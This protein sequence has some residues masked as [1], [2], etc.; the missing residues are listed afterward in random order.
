MTRRE[1]LGFSALL[2]L[3]AVMFLWNLS[4]NGWA[5]AYYAAA[6]QA[7]ALDWKAFFFGSSDPG[8]SITVDKLPAS[9]WVS[10]LSVR[11]WGLSSWSLL[12][13]QALMGVGTVAL[14]YLT[15]RRHF[16]M[17]AAVLAGAVTLLTPAGAIM[18]RYNNPDALLTLLLA[19]SLYVMVRAVEDGRWGWLIGAGIVLGLGF[20]TKSAQALI[21]LPVLGFVYLLCGPGGVGR[22]AWQLVVALG[23]VAGAAGWWITIAENLN[24]SNRPYAGGSFTNSF[25]EVLLRQNGLGRIVG[26]AAGG[27]PQIDEIRP[28]PLKLLTHPTFGTQ[29][30][31]LLVLAVVLLISSMV[32][33]RGRPRGDP[34][35]AVLLLAGGWLIAYTGVFSFMSGVMNPYYLVALAPP[36]GIVI[37]SGA[38]LS[39]AARRWLPFRIAL[40]AA[41]LVT[42]LL[43]AAYLTISGGVGAPLAL[44]VLVLGAIITQLLIFRIRSQIFVRTTA[45]AATITCLIGPALFTLSGVLTPHTGI[46]PAA[47]L[48]AAP[49]VIDSP[50]PAAW[51][52]A[53]P[54]GLRGTGIGHSPQKAALELLAAN[55]GKSRWTAATPGA[56]NAARYQLESGAS[57]M[58][59]G[60]FNGSVPYP[61]VDQFR[62]Y[63]RAGHIRYYI[64][65]GDS[66]DI[67]AEAGF[68]DEVTNW[69]KANFNPQIMGEV[70]LYD[71]Q[72]SN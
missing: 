54:T 14:T 67:S 33:L 21:I 59:V 72:S 70:E 25:V 37:G 13:P 5:N 19:V 23:T 28:G 29:G 55:A 34:K 48:P 39:W 2:L 51:P 62:D 49:T 12:V 15:V 65:R 9:I 1:M 47:A 69:V 45:V 20:L 68:A 35:R 6:A 18:F 53:A 26:A 43:A 60:G 71:L 56:L 42:A 63:A 30:S 32:L 31:W 17:P 36:L 24:A 16:R 11:L 41:F 44:V 10:S 52:D 7:G 8:N 4:I 58:P 61:T 66:Q 27:S 40:A 46:W 3:A 38:Q 22:R 50:A 57:V 64:V